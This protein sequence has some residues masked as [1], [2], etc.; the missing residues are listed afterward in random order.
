MGKKPV[1][2]CIVTISLGKGGLERTTAFLSRLLSGAGYDV[3]IILLND[4]IDYP[5]KGNLLNLGIA[6]GEKDTFRKRWKRFMQLKKYVKINNFDYFIDARNRRQTLIESLYLF[7]IYKRSK[8]VYMVHSFNTDNYFT[9]NKFVGNLIS[10]KVDKIVCVSQAIKK[11]VDKQFNQKNKTTTI[12]NPIE[13]FS[14][15][16]PHEKEQLPEKFLL[17]LGRIDDNVKNF[18]LLIDAF[19]ASNLKNEGI[20]LLIVGDGP[21]IQK[22][23]NYTKGK[24]LIDHVLMKPFTSNV[25]SYLI[26]AHFLVLTSRYEGFPMVLI[27][28]LSVGTPVVSVDCES[29]PNEI[30]KNEVNGLLVENHNIEKLAEAMNRMIQDEKLYAFCKKNA[31]GSIQHLSAENILKQWKEILV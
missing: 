27:E 7:Y 3:H 22:V 19:A 30:V 18:E 28:S 2:I 16:I 10:R 15:T 24:K 23:K 26:N 5:Y 25:F 1:K 6:K 17:F 21:D 12:Y 9:K 8:K 31:K 14:S 20:R 13:Q 11:K 4:E 29:G